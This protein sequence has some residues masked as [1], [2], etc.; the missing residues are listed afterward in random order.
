MN[1]TDFVISLVDASGGSIQGR[2]LLQKRAYFLTLLAGLDIDVDFD[3]HFYG[4]Y[5]AV[6][7]NTMTQLK[8]LSFIEE[9]ATA[10]GVD[11]TGFEM[12]RYDYR[13]TPDGQKIAEKLRATPEYGQIRR[14]VNRMTESGNLNY[15]E[16][17]IA[18]K[19]FFILKKR[20]ERMSKDEIIREARKFDWNIQPPSLDKAVSFLERLGVLQQ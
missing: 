18:A 14:I 7:D 5:S 15:M 11:N 17:S 3:A 6:V 9:S 4:P 8:N 12:K 16:L 13:L 19:A 2:T 1:A 20:K 10:Y